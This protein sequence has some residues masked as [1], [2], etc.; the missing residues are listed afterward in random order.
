VQNDAMTRTQHRLVPRLSATSLPWPTD[1]E[2]LFLG[3]RGTG[4]GESDPPGDRFPLTTFPF[5]LILE[6][7][8]GYG[9]FLRHLSATNPDAR[10]IGLEIASECLLHVEH[11]IDRGD[12]PNAR[13]LF[14][15]ADTALYH[16]FEPE[17]IDQIHV[18]FPDPWF[19][20]RH[21]RRRLMQRPTTDLM[22]SRLKPG[23]MLYLATDIPEYAEMSDEALRATPGLVNTLG[24][25]WSVEPLPGRIVSKYE[26]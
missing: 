3:E 15:R 23:G 22:A 7:G 11:Q 18:N 16:L 24:A 12:M 14:S 20:S 5:P 17:T 4:N 9:H 26:R 19:K 13:V 2:T 21:E 8:F 6:I 25:A 10:I 1:W